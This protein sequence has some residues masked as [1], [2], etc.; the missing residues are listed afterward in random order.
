MKKNYLDFLAEFGIGGAHPGGF[1]LTKEIFTGLD[2]PTGASILEIGCGTGQTAEYLAAAF[3][4]TITA[5]DNHSIM[6]EKAAERLNQRNVV[7]QYG[8]A[9]HL[10]FPDQTFDLVIA[11]SVISFTSSIDQTLHEM[12][13]VLKKEGAMIA[14]EMTADRPLCKE[15]EREVKHLYGVSAILTEEEW[16]EK[17]KR[18]GF[19]SS[20]LLKTANTFNEEILTE[21]RLSENISEELYDIWDAHHAFISQPDL[22]LSYRVFY[23]QT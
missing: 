14:I 10:H 21:M 20:D 4:C 23:C 5:I 22:P 16:M 15:Q 11:E 6:L 7:V 17:F 19:D 18:A 3:D 1:S 8:N 12:S 13:R 9:E 2:L